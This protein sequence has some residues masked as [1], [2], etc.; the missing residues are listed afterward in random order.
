MGATPGPPYACHLV[1]L[2]RNDTDHVLTNQVVVAHVH[3]QSAAA[4]ADADAAA[5]L[6]L[7]LL[8]HG[9]WNVSGV[10]NNTDLEV[11]AVSHNRCS[12]HYKGDLG[13]CKRR[14]EGYRATSCNLS[15]S[16][17]TGSH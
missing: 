8:L 1:C 4:D 10:S 3:I 17:I 14:Q 16:L 11:H 2:Q 9:I 15:H 5:M 12:R 7:L 13:P 6:L